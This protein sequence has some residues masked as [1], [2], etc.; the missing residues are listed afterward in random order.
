MAGSEQKPA[1]TGTACREM[2]IVS[3]N[4]DFTLSLIQLSP[5]S[6]PRNF[7]DEEVQETEALG[8]QIRR[9]HGI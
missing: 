1:E 3:E 5:T 8:D 4:Y 2:R 9:N 7:V 6:G